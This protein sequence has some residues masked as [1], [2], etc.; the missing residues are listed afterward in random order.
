MESFRTG[1]GRVCEYMQ[2]GDPNGK[3]VVFLHGTPGTAGSA[4]LLE[5][6]TPRQGVRLLA[7]SRPGYGA[8]TATAPGLLSAGQD[9]G[10]LASRL[11]V[12]EFAALGVSGG[13]PF[14]L[15]V[16]AT[17]TTRVRHILIA[18]G[19]APYHEIAPEVLAPE[20]VEAMD[21]LAAGDV[22]GAVARV[23]A[24]VR[25]DFDALSQLPVSEFEAA[26]SAMFP[27]TEHYF[28]ARPDGRRMSSP[29]LTEH[30][31]AMTGLCATTSAGT[32]RGTSIC[33]MSLLR[34][35][36]VTVMLTRWLPQCTASGWLPGCPPGNSPSTPMPIM[37]RC[38][39]DSGIGY[40]RPWSRPLLDERSR[41]IACCCDPRQA[42]GGQPAWQ[43]PSHR[44]AGPE[45][46]HDT[47]CF[48]LDLV[49]ATKA[50]PIVIQ[51]TSSHACRRP[52][53][54]TSV[55]LLMAG[56]GRHRRRRGTWL[57][58][59]TRFASRSERSSTCAC[60]PTA[61]AGN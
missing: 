2:V 34:S 14:A 13:G 6:A 55:R 25:R 21:L 61:R 26:F 15:A 32:G 31:H 24:G 8:T 19:P 36:L 59:P 50:T 45:H 4:V 17:L 60:S 54:S 33:T 28:D 23:T 16:G 35:S 1:D 11:G 44:S 20:D 43:V 3:P 52:H 39:S 53:M 37:A 9:V 12:E 46:S 42:L 41:P 29:M 5:D 30:S 18:G 47:K 57:G 38:A 40:S 22:D 7:L 10:E 56:E 51:E 49:R 58:S 27:P 48:T